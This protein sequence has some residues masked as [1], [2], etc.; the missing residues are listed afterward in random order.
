MGAYDTLYPVD[1][2]PY[3]DPLHRQGLHATLPQAAI[4]Q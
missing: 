1:Q 3:R 4:T 2:Q